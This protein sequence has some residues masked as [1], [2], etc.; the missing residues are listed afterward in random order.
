MNETTPRKKRK[1]GR[2]IESE[3]EDKAAIKLSDSIDVDKGD[4]GKSVVI[5]VS[6][7]SS[8]MCVFGAM[9]KNTS[10]HLC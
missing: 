10:F 5:S 1:R 4:G 6:I 8:G 9:S 2:R 3:V 7:I